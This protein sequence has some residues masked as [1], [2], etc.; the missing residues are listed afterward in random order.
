MIRYLFMAAPFVVLLLSGLER[1]HGKPDPEGWERVADPGRGLYR[2]SERRSAVDPSPDPGVLREWRK[3]GTTLVMRVCYLGEFL[4]DDISS[5]YLDALRR[6]FEA[7]RAGGMKAIVRF[8]YASSMEEVDQRQAG[9]AIVLRHVEQLAPVFWGH[10]D[11]LHCVQA[12]FIGA[13]GEW[14]AMHSDFR[15]GDGSL[16]PEASRRLM[17]ALLRAVPEPIFLQVRTPWQ[18]MMLFEADMEGAERVGHHNDCFLASAN[19]VGT[20]RDREGEMVW[21]EKQTETLPMGGETC[22]VSGTRSSG[23]SALREMATLHFNYLNADY[24]PGVLES[25]R[26]DGSYDEIVARLG[27][28]VRLVTAANG[29]AG[30]MLTLINDG[31]ATPLYER[32]LEWRGADGVVRTIANFSMRSLKP[33]EKQD[34]LLPGETLPI[35]VRLPD[36][37]TKLRER[38]EFCSRL[39]NMPVDKAGWH[40]VSS[41]VELAK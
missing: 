35:E 26:Q 7:L 5:A 21:L 9:E 4:N 33:G 41:Q 25:W 34:I 29:P 36:S 14:H 15:A 11:V 27:H 22:G 37:A 40:S 16:S 28:R 6:D 20:Y 8:A 23:A 18:K 24:H 12:G 3:E 13:W 10:S 1:A 31:F 2:H 19:D 30:V 17:S 39:V 32:S 38:G